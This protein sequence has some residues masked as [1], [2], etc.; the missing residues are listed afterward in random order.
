[1]QVGNMRNYT[2]Y[3]KLWIMVLDCSPYLDGATEL[4]L[5]FLI[6]HEGNSNLDA[7]IKRMQS[8]LKQRVN[9]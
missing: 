4:L 2:E 5:R 7:F 1:M 3:E 9:F 8:E 6:L